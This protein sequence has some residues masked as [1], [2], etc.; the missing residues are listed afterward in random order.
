MRQSTKHGL[1]SVEGASL[2]LMDY[3]AGQAPYFAL[4]LFLRLL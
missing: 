3:P 1:P 2:P 4:T